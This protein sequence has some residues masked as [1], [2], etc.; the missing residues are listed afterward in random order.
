MG[1]GKWKAWIGTAIGGLLV[2]A[3]AIGLLWRSIAEQF[4]WVC[5]PSD[6]LIDL[7]KAMFI[8]GVVTI[9]VDP[10]L[11]RRLLKRSQH[12]YFPPSA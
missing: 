6:T 11:K 5:C 10:F 7:C 2:F 1:S 3:G 12:G 4:S 9:A 8:A